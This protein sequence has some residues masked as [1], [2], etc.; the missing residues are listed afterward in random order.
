METL[1]FYAIDSEM[2]SN[3]DKP[4]FLDTGKR[5]IEIN[6]GMEIFT[7]KSLLLL[8]KTINYWDFF[9]NNEYEIKQ[10]IDKKDMTISY[11]VSGIPNLNNRENIL[12]WQ[13]IVMYTI[14]DKGFHDLFDEAI[15]KKCECEDS[16]YYIRLY[17][18]SDDEDV[19]F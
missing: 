4:N 15:L 11:D 10:N 16:C 17:N 1:K 7:K 5:F 12:E 18:H 9:K 3:I 19:N 8:K 6:N 13:Q 2:E 14:N